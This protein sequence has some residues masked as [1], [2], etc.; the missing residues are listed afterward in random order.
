MMSMTVK[1]TI[2]DLVLV[3]KESGLSDEEITRILIKLGFTETRVKQ[4]IL[5]LSL[6]E[7]VGFN[8][9]DQQ[10]TWTYPL[11]AENREPTLIE[12]INEL[13]AILENNTRLLEQLLSIITEKTRFN[14]DDNSR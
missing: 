8:E 14:I 13:N 7:K 9:T 2:E 3:F 1:K 6:L 10:S 4:T 12:R 11:P 5:K